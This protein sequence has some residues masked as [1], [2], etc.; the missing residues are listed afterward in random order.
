MTRFARIFL[1]G[2][3]VLSL[4][5]CAAACALW[6]RS[7][8]VRDVVSREDAVSGGARGVESYAGAVRLVDYGPTANPLVPPPAPATPITPTWVL[9]N[10]PVPTG[11]RPHDGLRSG[12]GDV[13]WAAAGFCVVALSQP[14]YPAGGFSGPFEGR[15]SFSAIGSRAVLVIVIPYWA[16]VVITAIR[17]ARSAVRFFRH[18]GARARRAAGQCERCGYDLRATPDR[19][20]ECGTVPP[21]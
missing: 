1:G 7:Y 15:V 18:R 4:V 8:H 5:V 10:D 20:P 11:A 21:R 9:S 3:T 2:L 12:P 6:V 19:C 17:P 13:V 16:I 14:V